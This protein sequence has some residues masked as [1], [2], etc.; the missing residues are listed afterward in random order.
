MATKFVGA[1][2]DP[3]NGPDVY[4]GSSAPIGSNPDLAA[5]QRRKRQWRNQ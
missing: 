4:V 1:N 5:E 3:L 2:P